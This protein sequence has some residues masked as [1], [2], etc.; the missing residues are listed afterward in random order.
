ML[1]LVTLYV[2]LQII[3]TIPPAIGKHTDSGNGETE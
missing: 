2:Y 1:L 3:K